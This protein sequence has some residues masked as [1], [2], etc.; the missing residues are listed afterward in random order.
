MTRSLRFVLVAGLPL[1]L[2]ASIPAGL[3][4]QDGT[5]APLYSAEQAEAGKAVFERVCA[6][7][8][9]PDMT[10]KDDAPPLAGPYFG[11]SWGHHKVSELF[12]FVKGN[13]PFDAPGTLDEETYLQVVAY[14]LSKNGIPAG[15]A[16]LA[17]G[18]AGVIT[19]PG[20]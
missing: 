5:A 14:V 6:K 1:F 12:E 19:V 18:D 13:M 17:K 4:A 3:S 11:S 2:I 8:H 20:D 10:G 7:C 9:Q 16:P 15:P